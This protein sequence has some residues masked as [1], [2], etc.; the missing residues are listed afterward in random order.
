MMTVPGI[1]RAVTSL[2]RSRP[3]ITGIRRSHS[4]KSNGE[5]P[6]IPSASLPSPASRTSYPSADRIFPSAS[7]SDSSSSTISIL[8]AM[9]SLFSPAGRRFT[10]G[11]EHDGEGRPPPPPLLPPDLPPPRPR[12]LARLLGREE[13]VEEEG[14][15]AGRDPA[16]GV[17]H[18]ERD[19]APR[20][21]S[22]RAQPFAVHL[23]RIRGAPPH[24]HLPP[25]GPP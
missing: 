25:P 3:P 19:P 21:G 6:R 8:S 12:A 13:R 4:R 18:G 14:K 11:R 20:S 10:G 23:R 7:R 1:P 15:I 5:A 22:R 17:R 9:A 24:R 2:R 16:A